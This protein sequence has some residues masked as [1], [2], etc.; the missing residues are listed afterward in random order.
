MSGSTVDEIRAALQGQVIKVVKILYPDAKQEGTSYRVPNVSGKATKENSANSDSL[1]IEVVD[2]AKKG[3]WIDFSTGEK[4]GIIDLIMVSQNLDFPGALQ[5][6]CDLL[7]MPVPSRKFSTPLTKQGLQH[8][9]ANPHAL[10]A[11]KR[12]LQQ[13]PE[14][15]AYLTGERRGLTQQTIEHFQLGLYSYT[16][17]DGIVKFK[18]ALNYP[19]LDSNGQAVSRFLRSRIPNVTFTPDDR[20]DWTTGE[21]STYWVTEAGRRQNLLVCEGPKDGWRI[22]QA[23]QND[24]LLEQLCIITSTHGK[25]IPEEWKTPAFWASWGAVYAAQDADKTGDELALDIRKHAVRDVKRVRVPETHGK[26]WTEFFNS[27]GTVNEF[28]TLLQNALVAAEELVEAAVTSV[29]PEED[30]TF[31]VEPVDLSR[32][33]IGGHLYYPFRS[34]DSRTVDGRRSR[35]WRDQVLRSDGTICK[36]DYLW[37][38]PGTPLKD[39][40]LALDDGTIL[41]KMPEAD[42]LLST[43]TTNAITRFALARKAGRS[44]LT[45]TPAKMLAQIDQHLRS[46][47]ILPY[48]DDFAILTYVTVTS[49]VQSI[50]EAV[51]L[52]LVMGMA[53]SGKSELGVAIA[54]LSC[55]AVILNG[56]TSAASVARAIDSAGGLA[57][58]DDLEGIG[59]TTKNKNDFG[60]LKQQLKVSYKKAT[61]K[62]KWTNTTTMRLEELNFFGVKIINNTEGADEILGS[63]MLKIYTRKIGKQQLGEHIRP[64]ELSQQQLVELRNNLHMWAMESAREIDVLYQQQYKRHE[65]RQSEITAPLRLLAEFMGEPVF[66][67][68]LAAALHLQATAPEEVE[69]SVELLE[70]ALKELIRQGYQDAIAM[71]QLEFEM[72][73]IT[74][75]PIWGQ[76]STTQISEW[77]EPRWVGKQLRMM[78]AIA[79]RDGDRPR[80]WGQQVRTYPLDPA[81]VANTITELHAEGVPVVTERL[82]PLMYCTNVEC[83]RC[84]YTAFCDFQEKKTAQV[85]K[86]GAHA[87][88]L[89]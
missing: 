54:E 33:F 16:D 19:Q 74:G 81:F 3:V 62:K 32:A 88:K 13:H 72:I 86:L 1:S 56:Q 84:P 58:I 42:P 53:G 45:L 12:R 73:R 79:T 7:A 70:M 51:P 57:V 36:A 4:G 68:R 5:W 77:R 59:S 39:R 10:K 78:G 8:D 80:L 48:D 2:P 47:I 27:G 15:L 85:K 46:K 71:P 35:R 22:W 28:Q 41:T 29:A 89:N 37:A 23:L 60:E 63:R 75:S 38:E 82:G 50:F 14:A 65:E 40:M 34:G 76:T 55:N 11:N 18:D 30:G 67:E 17:K 44:A 25:L 64:S 31:Q 49:Y 43:F 21:P 6:A 52:I 9:Y 66:A 61:A 26:D 87:A 20:K 69:S 24:A 83:P